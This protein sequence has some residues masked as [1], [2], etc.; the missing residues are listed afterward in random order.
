MTVPDIRINVMLDGKRLEA[1]VLGLLTRFE[2]RESDADPTVAA[3]RF[4][5]TQLP[6]GEF[7]PVDEALFAP[8]ARLSLDVV[9]DIVVERVQFPS[10]AL[11]DVISCAARP[12]LVGILGGDATPLH[13]ER[14]G[15]A[16]SEPSAARHANRLSERTASIRMLPCAHVT[17]PVSP[18]ES[19]ERHAGTARARHPYDA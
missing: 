3:L 19:A 7:A 2:V 10:A 5:M 14:Q 16:A 9:A 11:H 17:Q 1:E 18:D 12:F 4:S 13:L 8:A 6:D 15:V